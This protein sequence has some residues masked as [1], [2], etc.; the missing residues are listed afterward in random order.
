[1]TLTDVES[2]VLLVLEQV[3]LGLVALFTQDLQVLVRIF[4]DSRMKTSDVCRCEGRQH[5]FP[6][7]FMVIACREIADVLG[8]SY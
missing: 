2:H 1:M 6:D 7:F 3:V 4:P 5:H 8:C